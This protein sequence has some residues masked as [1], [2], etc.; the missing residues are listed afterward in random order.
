MGNNKNLIL[1]LLLLMAGGGLTFGLLLKKKKAAAAKKE[2]EQKM[3][4]APAPLPTGTSIEVTHKDQAKFELDVVFKYKEATATL[5]AR[6]GVL[7]VK[8]NIDSTFRLDAR[9]DNILAS[10]ME[11]EN[12]VAQ[13]LIPFDA[14]AVDTT[15]VEVPIQGVQFG[16]TPSTTQDKKDKMNGK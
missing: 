9:T 14:K 3:N 10:I 11:G 13:K 16:D 6:N 7:D 8:E 1:L 5:R 4:T 12:V 15:A 2:K